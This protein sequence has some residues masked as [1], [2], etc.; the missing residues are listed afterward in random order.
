MSNNPSVRMARTIVLGY[1]NK[2]QA[3]SFEEK[4]AELSL[5]NTEDERLLEHIDVMLHIL[6]EAKKVLEGQDENNI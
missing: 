4:L 6:N 5:V 3:L 1:L 2:S